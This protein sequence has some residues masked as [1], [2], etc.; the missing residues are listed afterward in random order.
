MKSRF[1]PALAA[2]LVIIAVAGP[3]PG[4]GFDYPR[5]SHAG[6][7][8]TPLEAYERIQADPRGT[9]MV[10]V[11]TR[12]EYVFVGHPAMAHNIPIQFWKAEPGEKGM[13]M[14]F[15]H[16]FG[17]DLESRFDREKVTVIFIC[18]SGNR[19]ITAINSALEAGFRADRLF[20]VLGGFEGGK[21]K[22]KLSLYRGQRRMGGWRNEGLPWTY[23]LDRRLLY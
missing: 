6:G 14:V 2:L 11:R 13:G 9:V 3:A 19:S 22:S 20:N 8:L 15:N 7:D 4:A 18:R 17:R 1:V 10:D 12:A 21:I 16:N 23:D 5:K